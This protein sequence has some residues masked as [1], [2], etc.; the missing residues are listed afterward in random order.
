MGSYILHHRGWERDQGIPGRGKRRRNSV[1]RNLGRGSV[2]LQGGEKW[3]AN[4]SLKRGLSGRRREGSNQSVINAD[5]KGKKRKG[6][7]RFPAKK[8]PPL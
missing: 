6:N 7:V 4:F 2:L 3:G 1:N 8:N 5:K